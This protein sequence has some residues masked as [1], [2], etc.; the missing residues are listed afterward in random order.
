MD[1]DTD[2]S[3]SWTTDLDMAFSGS[4][5]QDVTMILEWQH[6]PLRL[7]LGISMLPRQHGLRQQPRAQTSEWPLVATWAIDTRHG[8]GG[9]PGF[10]TTMALGDFTGSSCLPVSR[11]LHISSFTSL[12][13]AQSTWLSF[14]SHLSTT[15]SI[16]PLSITYWLI[17]LWC[18]SRYLDIFQSPLPG[19]GSM[20]G[21][22]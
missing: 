7:A 10:D 17:S 6:R 21:L 1:L 19:H 8:P 13:N 4:L 16:F 11:H 22:L 18:C 15:Y 5:V 2:P 12:H 3:C 14:L 20:A 9:S